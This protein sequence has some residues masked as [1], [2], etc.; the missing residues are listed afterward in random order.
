MEILVIGSSV[1]IRRLLL[2]AEMSTRTPLPARGEREKD[3]A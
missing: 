3:E 1:K 2:I